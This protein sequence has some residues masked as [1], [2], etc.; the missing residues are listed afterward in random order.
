MVIKSLDIFLFLSKQHDFV[1]SKKIAAHF[2]VSMRTVKSYIKKFNMQHGKKIIISTNRGYK[3]NPQCSVKNILSQENNE[4]TGVSSEQRRKYIIKKILMTHDNPIDVFD[5]CEELHIGYSTLMG[6]FSKLNKIFSPYEVT[7]SVKNEQ[8]YLH[9]QEKKVRKM[10]SNWIYNNGKN[11]FMD[12]YQLRTYF[13]K[14]DID[15][16]AALMQ[17]FFVSHDIYINDFGFNFVLL[18]L[19]IMID[20]KKNNKNVTFAKNNNKISSDMDNHLCELLCMKL[21]NEFAVS[22]DKAD[23]YDIY[24]LIK[25]NTIISYPK[26]M[27]ELVN[28]IGR[29]LINKINLYIKSIAKMYFIDLSNKSFIIPFSLHVRNLLF[30]IRENKMI[31]NPMTMVIKTE[32]PII[33]DIAI[34]VSLCLKKDF[35]V[36]IIEDE[37][38]FLAIHIAGEIERQNKTQDKL[39]AVIFCP[40]YLNI[41][42]Y[43]RN[44]LMINF[45]NQLNIVDIAYNID[46]LNKMSYDILFTGIKLPSAY[47][48]RSVVEIFPYAIENSLGSIQDAINNVWKNRKNR[49]LKRYFDEHF[50]KRLFFSDIPYNSR[51]EVIEFLCNNL[52]LLKYVEKGF[53]DN[54]FQR[55]RAANTAFDGIAI[56]HSV[57]MDAIKTCVSI[58]ISKKGIKWGDDKNIVH[59]VFLLAINK[60]HV[61]IFRKLYESL[62]SI[63]S[64]PLMIEELKKCNSFEEFKHLLV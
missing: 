8:V 55:E 27:K 11:F 29:E 45:G 31:S 32:N 33:Y 39:N 10:V 49:L 26:S 15:G 30:R 17:S 54:I 43:L 16:L 44:K 60:I 35:Q 6:D 24:L 56:P 57:Q 13:N 63:F 51:E 46:D 2:E 4:Y 7:V 62:I 9:G 21:Q 18:H 5:L 28:I 3:I 50:E 40:N 59:V 58:V 25:S 61:R 1:S 37:T 53:K 41:T 47:A 12:I 34:Y 23:R 36:D 22:W 14:V 48:N 19:A 42:N 64:T 52:K 20:C 38:A